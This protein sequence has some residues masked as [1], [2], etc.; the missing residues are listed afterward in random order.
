[1]LHI[2]VGLSAIRA[3]QQA[4]YAISNNVANANTEGYHR[5]RVELIDRNPITIGALQIGTGVEVEHLSRL[6]DT[7]TEGALISTNSLH[8][9]SETYLRILEQIE[10]AL[11]PTQ[12]S[13]TDSVSNFFNELEQL[14]AQP[15]TVTIRDAVLAAAYDV[16]KQISRL[17]S[18][19]NQ[20]RT[21]NAIEV[22]E[23]VDAVNQATA[24]I[25]E[26]NK[27]IRILS[28]SGTAPN[29]LLDQRDRLV[30][31][32]SKSVEIS[33]QTYLVEESPLVAANG[34]VLIAEEA[35][36]L[37]AVTSPD[38]HAAVETQNG[39][40]PVNPLSGALA[41]LLAGQE[42]ID[43]IQASLHEWATEF[44]QSIDQIHSTG[45]GHNQA[46]NELQGS[47]AITDVPSPLSEIE[48]PYDLN[49]GSLF[50]TL[51]HLGT[52]ERTT[53]EIIV[54]TATDSL[55]DVISQLDSLPNLSAS[56]QP[57]AKKL[58]L[59][60]TSGYAIDFAG[61][62]DAVPQSSTLTGT[63]S[64]RLSGF[65]SVT[66]NANWTATVVGSGTVGVTSGLQIELTDTISGDVIRSV[67]VGD[68]Y[69]PGEK[70]ELG[71]GIN[72]TLSIGT[73][74]AGESFQFDLVNN[75]DETGLLVALGI[76]TLFS[77]DV[78]TGL[79]VN[80]QVKQSPLNI[81]ASRTGQ[82]ADA[83]NLSRMIRL[84]DSAVFEQRNETIEQ[85]L[86]SIATITAFQIEA[87][88]AGMEYLNEQKIHLENVRDSVSGVDVNEELLNMLEFQRQFQAAS[89]FVTAVD[90]SLDELMRLIS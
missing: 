40:N 31:E 58:L 43:S 56:F 87:E 86:A 89:R 75:A 5:Q 65:P 4:L 24:Q 54:D 63:A 18:R 70:I 55:D 13:L 15:S 34:A 69:L 20:L 64:P 51:T 12:G 36:Q 59:R 8:S 29:T 49:S 25:A 10:A 74:N 82:A 53:Q 2:D 71:N 32:L 41:G 22:A 76:N 77:G 6:R 16:V 90:E 50:V 46:N 68:N 45:L 28:H 84:R 81:A 52:G 42:L 11:L 72:L 37:V 66:G 39:G 83:S 79:V 3:S 88:Q 27:D 62:I 30:S 26:L 57:D 38:G 80:E 9:E 78:E 7:A 67:S 47:R 23:E 44:V 73:L 1:M 61:G 17:D 35:T 21:N 60:A 48:T 85:R 14:A 33:L 19:M